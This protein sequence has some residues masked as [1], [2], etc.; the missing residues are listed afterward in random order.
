VPS[1]QRRLGRRRVYDIIKG[2]RIPLSRTVGRSPTAMACEPWMSPRR[3]SSRTRGR[4]VPLNVP[5][6][7]P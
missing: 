1:R 4:P 2:A 6:V 5:E 3:P 7:R